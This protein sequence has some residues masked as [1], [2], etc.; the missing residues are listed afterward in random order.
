MRVLMLT[1]AIDPD[2]AVLGSTAGWAAALARHVESVDVLCL[3]SGGTKPDGVGVWAVGAR[4]ESGRFTRF[5]A[6]ERT[7]ARLAART[8]VVF[9][10]MVPRYTCLAAPM[11]MAGRL[12]LLLWYTHR[13]DSFELRAATA[14]SRVVATAVPESFPFATPKLRVLGHGVDTGV[15]SPAPVAS[16]PSAPTIVFVGRLAPIKHQATLVEALARI[17]IAHDGVTAVFIGPEHDGGAYRRELHRLAERFGLHQRVHFAGPLPPARVVDWYR[18]AT[19][20]VNLSPDGLFDKAA[21]ESMVVGTPTVVAGAAFDPLLGQAAWLRVRAPDD[22]DALADVL[23]QLLAMPDG[24]RRALAM[25]VRQRAVDA[26]ALDRFILR[27]VAL[28]ESVR[29]Q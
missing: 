20:A 19:V 11:A 17:G 7:L 14:L 1:Q 23:R 22:A 3:R 21:L 24:E 16:P 2:D 18:R 12:P 10:H 6:F 15:F 25:D 26:H 28:M 4:G 13:H 29:R 8:D 5:I 9:T 27:L